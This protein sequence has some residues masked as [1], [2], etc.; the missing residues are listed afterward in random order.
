MTETDGSPED[1]RG[2]REVKSAARTVELL[3]LLAARPNSPA[4]LRELSDALGVPKSSLYALLRTLTARGWVL[5][6][7]TGTLYRLGSRA[8]LAGSTYLGADPYLGVV[9]PH[10]DDLGE[11]VDETFHLSRLDGLDVVYLATSESTQYLRSWSRVGRRL[12]AYSTSLGKALLAERD[13]DDLERHLPPVL[14]PLTPYTLTDRGALA[15]DLRRTRE[16][17]Y[18]IDSQENTLGLKCFGM[19]L[20]H[21]EPPTYAVSSSMPLDRLTPEREVEIVTAMS[22]AR[23]KI[24]RSPMPGSGE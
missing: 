10:L 5:A 12:P 20:R 22:A 2:V 15:E 8:V 3:E 1:A 21:A 4:P 11:R 23:E 24:E 9:H 16:R 13:G 18:A 14:I 19:A 17:G 7:R 6:D